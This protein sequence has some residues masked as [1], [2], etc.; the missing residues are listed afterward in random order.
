MMARVVILAGRMPPIGLMEAILK[1]TFF[2]VI[3]AALGGCVVVPVTPTETVIMREATTGFGQALVALRGDNGI[4]PIM[5]DATLEA[6]AVAHAADMKARGYFDHVAPDG[7]AP[8]DRARAAGYCRTAAIA[9]NIAEGQ[10]SEQQVL[11]AWANSPGHMR[12]MLDGRFIRF[13]LGRDG[14]TWVL[15]LGGAC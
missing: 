2:A 7:T 12:N 14:D 11:T 4:G 5:E 1:K 10:T 6:V 3:F 9:E 15:M 13:G 8:W